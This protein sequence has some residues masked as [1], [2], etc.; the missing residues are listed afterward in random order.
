M[1]V[2][3]AQKY[4]FCFGVKR[5][6]DIAQNTPNATTFGPLIHNEMEI[7][8]LHR[9]YGVSLSNTLK[10]AQT[11]QNVIVRTHGI[12]KEDLHTLKENGINVVDATCP[13]V[14]KPQNI[15]KKMSKEGYQLII[16]GDK[17]H[18]EVQGVASYGEDVLIVANIDELMKCNI[19]RRLVLLSQTTKQSEQFGKIAAWLISKASEVR[20]FN[21]ICNATFENQR[22]VLELSKEA[23]IIIVVGGKNSSNTKQ[24]L[25]IAKAQCVDSYL[26]E[27][28][29]ELE[30]EWFKHKKLCGITAGAST[31]DWIIESVKVEIEQ[32]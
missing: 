11:Y 26:V 2:K 17:N 10:E 28:K 29:E 7:Q 31:P 22:A 8:R 24:L 5:A 27:N 25:E 16:F 20:V 18:P 15:V 9:D 12:T 23:D 32:I 4:G 3:L 1:K 21:T 13:F 19:K 6:I 14:T 30:K